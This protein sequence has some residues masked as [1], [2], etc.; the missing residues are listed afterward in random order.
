MSTTT[1]TTTTTPAATAS[2]GIQALKGIAAILKNQIA[3]LSYDELQ[4]CGP[5]LITFFTFVQK[6]PLAVND[7]LTIG[8]Q[9][10]LLQAALMAAQ[11]TVESEVLV[12]GSSSLV[13][14]IQQ[15]MAQPAP[16]PAAV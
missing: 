3:A 4:A 14:L 9:V 5:S 13:T 10:V 11:T 16:T 1:T 15:M 7:P 2:L 6:N 12:N 8:P